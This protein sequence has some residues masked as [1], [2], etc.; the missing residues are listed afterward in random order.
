[1][2]DDYNRFNVSTMF[3]GV[4][5]RYRAVPKNNNLHSVGTLA[6]TEP[7]SDGTR[8][9]KEILETLAAMIASRPHDGMVRIVRCWVEEVGDHHELKVELD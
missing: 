2:S 9:T 5:R 8:F 1:M 4:K 6:T 3:D 7:R